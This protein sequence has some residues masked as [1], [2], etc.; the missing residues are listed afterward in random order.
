MCTPCWDREDGTGRHKTSTEPLVI[1]P[2]LPPNKSKK[3]DKPATRTQLPPKHGIPHTRTRKNVA[4]SDSETDD[5]KM[6]DAAAEAES[7]KKQSMRTN[8][9]HTAGSS[10]NEKSGEV[11]NAIT[12]DALKH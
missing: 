1:L 12:Q 11:H 9:D 2:P 6:P 4:V 7:S 5:D 3:K 8:T 10:N